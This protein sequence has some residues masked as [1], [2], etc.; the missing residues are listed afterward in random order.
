VSTASTTVEVVLPHEARA[1][2]DAIA[3]AGARV[4]DGDPS[5][6]AALEDDHDAEA[7]TEPL[8]EWLDPVLSTDTLGGSTIGM[9]WVAA[10]SAT[11]RW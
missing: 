9:R 2:L 4:T 3:A 5:V 6:L 11:K 10:R 1:D 8:I 7:R